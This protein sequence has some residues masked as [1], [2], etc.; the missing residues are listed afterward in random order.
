MPE[1]R[2]GMPT[3]RACWMFGIWYNAKDVGREG[4]VLDG[5]PPTEMIERVKAILRRD[6]KLGS[7]A[8]I[9]DDMPLV[10]GS[11]DLDSLDLLLLVTSIEKEFGVRIG[12]KQISREAFTSVAT[13]AAFLESGRA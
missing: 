10:G 3:G 11:F 12:D 5:S 4:A 2:P 6:L 13:L 1:L 9:G 8:K 7:D